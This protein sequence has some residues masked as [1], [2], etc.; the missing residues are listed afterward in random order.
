MKDA[1]PHPYPF[2]PREKG[3]RSSSLHVWRGVGGEDERE[4][5][6]TTACG[7]DDSNRP[8]TDGQDFGKQ[9]LRGWQFLRSGFER[10]FDQRLPGHPLP[11]V[12]ARAVFR[13][14]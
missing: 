7:S 2:S 8:K 4:E 13:R 11:T 12:E 6:T 14:A 1:S 9:T 10:H 5:K 3:T